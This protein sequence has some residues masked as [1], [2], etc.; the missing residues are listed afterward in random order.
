MGNERKQPPSREHAGTPPAADHDSTQN[1]GYNQRGHGK[2]GKVGR[3]E[4]DGVPER[5]GSTQPDFGQ[6]GA[7]LGSDPDAG[8]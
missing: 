7:P 4:P 8:R 2:G 5:D 1:R 6:A 3:G